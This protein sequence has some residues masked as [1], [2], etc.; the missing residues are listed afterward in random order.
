MR[1]ERII[2]NYKIISKTV[3]LML[4][5]ALGVGCTKEGDIYPNDAT[6]IV[7]I[8]DDNN[9][10]L[11]GAKIKFYGS[12]ADYQNALINN[13]SVPGLD[14]ALSISSGNTFQLK[15]S[16]AYWVLVTYKDIIRGIDLSNSGI[17]AKINPL[18]KGS[19][20]YATIKIAPSNAI[21]A[22]W[23]KQNTLPLNIV[24]DGKTYPLNTTT[25][26]APTSTGDPNVTYV[27][28]KPGT[29]PYYAKGNLGCVWAGSFT[30]TAGLFK[31]IEFDH[32]IRGIVNFYSM[33]TDPS[34]YP[35]TVTLD[36][37]DQAGAVLGFLPSFTCG[38]PQGNELTITRAPG[39]YSYVAR[40]S[41]GACVYT[42]RFQINSDT[43]IVIKFDQ[44]N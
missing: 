43:C 44:C 5:L 41:D 39:D 6:L 2:K 21:V 26:A 9:V 19:E 15:A 28:L 24:V 1:A 17:S 37:N 16:T 34:K 12:E 42:G 40:S 7:T 23:T 11:N 20:I 35:I 33:E 8:V 32:C 36:N 31:A 4:F 27:S 25:T 10:K 3:L 13:N 18:E 30:V 38:N 22:F 29:Y 14:S